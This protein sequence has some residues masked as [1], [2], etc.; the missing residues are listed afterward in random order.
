MTPSGIEPATF[1]FLAQPF[2]H[3]ATA[4]HIIIIIIIIILS[5]IIA[6][7]SRPTLTVGEVK[8]SKGLAFP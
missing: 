3:C 1:R 7:I 4:V 6:L 2:N 5:V 8:D